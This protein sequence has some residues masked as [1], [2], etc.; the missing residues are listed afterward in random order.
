MHNDLK[1]LR[2]AAFAL[3]VGQDGITNCLLK[4]IHLDLPAHAEISRATT[5]L[6]AAMLH[7]ERST[8]LDTEPD[9]HPGDLPRRATLWARP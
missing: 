7:S 2:L 4:R 6:T 3:M 8:V 9:L 1:W 5:I